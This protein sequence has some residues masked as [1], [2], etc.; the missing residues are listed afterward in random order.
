MDK[1]ELKGAILEAIGTELDCWLDSKDCIKTGYEWE[2]TLVGHVQR[3]NQII[4]QRSLGTVPK[5]RNKK[6]FARV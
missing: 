2:T 1:N 5:S 4:V 6:N 3:I